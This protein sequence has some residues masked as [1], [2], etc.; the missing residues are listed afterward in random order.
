[1]PKIL[2]T[3][4]AQYTLQISGVKGVWTAHTVSPVPAPFFHALMSGGLWEVSLLGPNGSMGPRCGLSTYC[5][6][7]EPAIKADPSADITFLDLRAV[8]VADSAR[9]REWNLSGSVNTT[10]RGLINEV[11]FD[12]WRCQGGGL[13]TT[14]ACLLEANGSQIDAPAPIVVKAGER[15]SFSVEITVT[16][17]P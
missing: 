2:G 17:T 16:K 10:G 12:R 15:V 3:L 8:M 5:S 11:D 14:G 6:D 4:N 13:P 7:G 9:R 1:M